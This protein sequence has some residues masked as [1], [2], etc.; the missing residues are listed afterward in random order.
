MEKTDKALATGS[1][2]V[3]G[4][5]GVLREPITEITSRIDTLGTTSVDWWMDTVPSSDIVGG[6]GHRFIH[7]HHLR[8][9]IAIFEQHGLDGLWDFA[10]H[11]GRDFTTEHGLPLPGGKI[12]FD[13]I[14]SIPGLDLDLGIAVDWF[15]VNLVD[16][17][18]AATAGLALYTIYKNKN[19]SSVLFIGAGIKFAF[20]LLTTNPLMIGG[21][22]LSAGW[23]MLRIIRSR[24]YGTPSI[25][26]PSLSDGLELNYCMNLLSAN[27]AQKCIK[28]RLSRLA[29]VNRMNIVRLSSD[30]RRKIL[31]EML[32]GPPR[33]LGRDERVKML[34]QML[35]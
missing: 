27:E 11:M 20:G 30:E 10:E 9:A 3:S 25:F 32:N 29:R 2:F 7:G 19:K 26:L 15:C 12:T 24:K 22:L 34:N 14:D 33:A 35:S 13:L 21:A 18:S 17:L 28:D 1:V 8:D 4:P 6:F 31:T 5:T 23:G 16:L